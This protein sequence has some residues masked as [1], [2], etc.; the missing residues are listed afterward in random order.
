MGRTLG[1]ALVGFGVV[2]LFL[3]GGISLVPKMFAWIRIDSVTFGDL[4][5]PVTTFLAIG[6]ILIVFGIYA[7]RK[8]P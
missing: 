5:I 1:I 7:L 8:D 3:G 2:A 4:P 6:T